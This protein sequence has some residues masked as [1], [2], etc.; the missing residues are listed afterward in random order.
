MSG[1]IPPFP[2]GVVLSLKKAQGQIF[3]ITMEQSV[4][5]QMS[6]YWAIFQH[7]LKLIDVYLLLSETII[8]HD[9]G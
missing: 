9:S 4:G 8:C 5:L 7:V 1:V 3:G 6:C 2:H